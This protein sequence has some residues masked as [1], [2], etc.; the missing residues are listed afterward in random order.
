LWPTV[1]FEVDHRWKAVDVAL[2]TAAAPTYF[3][4]HALPSGA[5]L[6]D[7]G[8]WANN[9]MGMAVVEAVGVLGWD[10]ERLKVLSLGCGD[11]VY[12]PAPDAGI[13]Q[14]GRDAINLLMQGQSFG[15]YGT[16][17]ILAGETNIH[18]IN[19]AVPKGV[20]TLDDTSKADRLAGMGAECARDA[21][22]MLRREFLV[23]RREEFT[24]FH[25]CRSSR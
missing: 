4:A 24:P 22:P 8:I 9:P 10:R 5:R 17:K 19:P 12:V 14:L 13:A 25:R 6:I 20:F 15:A 16:A 1:R 18:R 3:A 11:D 7:G 23:G 21:L 2:A